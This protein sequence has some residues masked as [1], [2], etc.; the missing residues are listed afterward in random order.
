MCDVRL[1][2]PPPPAAAARPAM[3]PHA[4]ACHS[5][6]TRRLHAIQL[7]VRLVIVGRLAAYECPVRRRIYDDLA[8]NGSPIAWRLRSTQR[9]SI[10]ALWR[11]ACAP[12]GSAARGGLPARCDS[13]W[14]STT[15]CNGGAAGR[16]AKEPVW[17]V[18]SSFQ[19]YDSMAVVAAVPKLR[20][21]FFTPSFHR[22]QGI[23]VG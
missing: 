3:A 17:D 21:R 23:E 19:M 12:V 1:R 2:P 14:F 5:I 18:V 4:C 16:T 9:N 13:E 6:A 7:R 8:R 20:K 15:F 22:V 10:E 11:R